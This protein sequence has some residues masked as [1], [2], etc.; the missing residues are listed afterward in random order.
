VQR[1]RL[2]SPP[3]KGV[4]MRKVSKES[5]KSFLEAAASCCYPWEGMT[6]QEATI[7]AQLFLFIRRKL[8]SKKNKEVSEKD[9]MNI[10][11]CEKA[12]SLIKNIYYT[13]EELSNMLF[14]LTE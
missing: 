14:D 2:T 1:G 12:D 10:L 6:Q 11:E 13:K 9:I 7:L 5:L 3:F 8:E 4:F